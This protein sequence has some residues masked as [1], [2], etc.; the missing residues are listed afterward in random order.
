MPPPG[1]CGN[2]FPT[3]SQGWASRQCTGPAPQL[4]PGWEPLGPDLVQLNPRSHQA[5]PHLSRS[6]LPSWPDRADSDTLDV[7]LTQSRRPGLFELFQEPAR[8]SLILCKNPFQTSTDLPAALLDS[9]PANCPSNFQPLVPVPVPRPYPTGPTLSL[10]HVI[11][12]YRYAP[13]CSFALSSRLASL[14]GL[15]YRLG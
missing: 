1:R 8:V 11:G 4:K 2:N 5:S 3:S 13:A 10:H 14:F 7:R 12:L 9:P 6:S 15:G